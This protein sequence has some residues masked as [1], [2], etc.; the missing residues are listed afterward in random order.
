MAKNKGAKGTQKKGVQVKDLKP[1]KAVKGGMIS[2]RLGIRRPI[3][4]TVT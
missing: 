4:Y 1:R 2:T 3:A